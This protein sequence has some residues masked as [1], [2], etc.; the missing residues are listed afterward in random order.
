MQ[1]PSATPLYVSLP[2][3]TVGLYNLT[4]FGSDFFGW[5]SRTYKLA[6]DNSLLTRYSDTRGQ[7]STIEAVSG[8]LGEDP[9][10]TIITDSA[11]QALTIVFAY[12]RAQNLTCLVPKPWFPAFY[13]VPDIFGCELKEYEPF[14]E[15]G[16]HTCFAAEAEMGQRLLVVNTPSNPIGSCVPR[17]VIEGAQKFS[18]RPNCFVA[19]D[20]SYYWA[21]D[22]SERLRYQHLRIYSLGKALGLPGLRLGAIAC[23]VPEM[24]RRLEA[25]KLQIGLH[26]CPLSEAVV[27]RLIEDFDIHALQSSWRKELSSRISKFNELLPSPRGRHYVGPFTTI[28][29]DIAHLTKS[30][31]V[32]GDAFGLTDHE[33]RICFASAELDW[34]GFLKNLSKLGLN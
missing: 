4:T 18:T 9:E 16:A 10:A 23:T 8:L 25:I 29:S 34:E 7:A 26:S 2:S 3:E 28:Q 5:D 19:W 6:V 33:T 17:A 1:L 20:L 14:S 32:K 30:V 12:A 13:A 31:G 27:R 15:T 21:H 22:I 24:T 11:S